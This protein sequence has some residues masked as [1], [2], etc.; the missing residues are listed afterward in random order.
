[1]EIS[2]PIFIIF[3]SKFEIV[4]LFG[5]CPH[6]TKCSQ[7]SLSERHYHLI[8]HI[9]WKQ[10]IPSAIPSLS[11]HAQPIIQVLQS[12]FLNIS[13]IYPYLSIT[14]IQTSITFHVGYN[15]ILYYLSHKREAQCNNIL[16]GFLSNKFSRTYLAFLK[17]CL[18]LVLVLRLCYITHKIS[19][20]ML[21]LFY[22]LGK[23]VKNWYVFLFE[24]FDSKPSGPELLFVGKFLF[25]LLILLLVISIFGLSTP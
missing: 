14:L 7:N 6:P 11:L 12:S 24:M 22:F 10:E 17:K 5:L 16:T 13:Q 19:G 1:M 3:F 25:S 20:E 8:W 15:N 4:G 23:S 2:C 9:S 21:L 18:C